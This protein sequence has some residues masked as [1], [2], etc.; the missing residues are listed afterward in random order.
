MIALSR[1]SPCMTGISIAMHAKSDWILESDYVLGG[2]G[3]GR[4]GWRL[5]FG[6]TCN[7]LLPVITPNLVDQRDFVCAGEQVFF[8]STGWQAASAGAGRAS[9]FMMGITYLTAVLYCRN[10]AAD[11]RTSWLI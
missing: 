9:R 1:I 6:M 10:A 8:L 3:G 2:K 5:I 7:L 11:G 4:D